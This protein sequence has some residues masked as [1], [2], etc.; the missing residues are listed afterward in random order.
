[1]GIGDLALTHRVA[2]DTHMQPGKGPMAFVQIQRGQA[3]GFQITEL[4][5]IRDSDKGLAHATGLTPR[6]LAQ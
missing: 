6:G 5:S 2:A 4:M 1:M 3:S